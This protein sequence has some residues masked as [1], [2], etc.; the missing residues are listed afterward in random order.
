MAMQRNSPKNMKPATTNGWL[1]ARGLP[2]PRPTASVPMA[3]LQVTVFAVPEASIPSASSTCL[4][5]KRSASASAGES[6]LGMAPGSPIGTSPTLTERG[7]KPA[8][9]SSGEVLTLA[10]ST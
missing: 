7:C 9:R 2:P 4:I 8:S 6:S 3:S 10:R 1:K 5:F